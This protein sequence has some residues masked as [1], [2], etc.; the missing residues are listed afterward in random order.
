MYGQ[1]L[2]V[3]YF[4]T[5]NMDAIKNSVNNWLGFSSLE[6]GGMSLVKNYRLKVKL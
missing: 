4:T 5:F 3:L 2:E 6:W 1:H